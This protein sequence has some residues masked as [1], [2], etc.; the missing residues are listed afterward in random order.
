MAEQ[1]TDEQVAEFKEAF[2]LFDKDGDG[3]VLVLTFFFQKKESL[4]LLTL[5][6]GGP[7]C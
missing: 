2:S 1:L 4:Y 5:L 7:L 6:C 3:K